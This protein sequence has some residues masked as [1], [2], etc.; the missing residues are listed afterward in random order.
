M[1]NLSS[2]LL[3]SLFGAIV[4]TSAPA[5]TLTVTGN[6]ASFKNQAFW[7]GTLNVG[8]TFS[9]TFDIKTPAIDQRMSDPTDGRYRSEGAEGY[10][11]TATLGTY[12]F[13]APESAS[14]ATIISVFRE[15]GVSND[16]IL[17]SPVIFDPFTQHGVTFPTYSGWSFYA[18]RALNAGFADDGFSNVEGMDLASGYVATD[19][20]FF[21]YNSLNQY[22]EVYGNATAVT[23][24]PSAIPE[25]STYTAIAGAL[26]LGL[27]AVRRRRQ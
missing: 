21:G 5:A 25:P 6:I 22:I 13:V 18:Y 15:E 20:F 23:Y 27:V 12:V 9:M 3:G 14:S 11:S 7:N 24:S 19:L 26:A 8:D 16:S 1:K 10:G 2:C 17:A 4:A